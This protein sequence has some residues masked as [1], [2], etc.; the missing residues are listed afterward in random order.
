[1]L[2]LVRRAYRSSEEAFHA[3]LAPHRLPLSKD[4]YL[5]DMPSIGSR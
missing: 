1:M 3:H 2:S 4:A 5:V